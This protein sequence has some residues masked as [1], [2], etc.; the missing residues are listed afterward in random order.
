MG[1]VGHVRRDRGA[2]AVK[3]ADACNP[4][5]AVVEQV[6][7]LGPEFQVHSF[8]DVDDFRQIGIE[9]IEDW[10]TSRIPAQVARC[11]WSYGRG[12]RREPDVHGT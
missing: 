1:A 12:A 7:E 2:A 3:R 9:V 4:V 5:L 8:S 10:G 6:E 11:A